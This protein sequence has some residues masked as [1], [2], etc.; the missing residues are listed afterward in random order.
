MRTM[1]SFV[2]SIRKFLFFAKEKKSVNTLHSKTCPL[3]KEGE[4]EVKLGLCKYPFIKGCMF[5]DDKNKECQEIELCII[6]GEETPYKKSD[7]IANR[8]FYQE[9]VGQRC[10]Y[11]AS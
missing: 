3:C 11:C 1:N 7:H 2:N 10:R 8:L 6:C 4:S 9:G 5:S